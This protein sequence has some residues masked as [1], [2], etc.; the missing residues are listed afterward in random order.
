MGAVFALL[1]GF[2]YWIPKILGK[3]YSEVLGKI[4]FWTLFL[5]VFIMTFKEITLSYI[6]S[7]YLI[8]INGIDFVLCSN[9][10]FITPF[11]LY[12]GKKEDL[13]S[14]PENMI[15]YNVETNIYNI[16][17]EIKGKAG[18]H[19]LVSDITGDTYIGSSTNLR[20]RIGVYYYQVRSDSNSKMYIIRA[21]K[22]YGLHNFCFIILDYCEP[23]REVCLRL[24]QLAF[25]LYFPT[26]NILK[27]AGSSKGF[28]H[29]PETIA[30]LKERFSGINHPKYGSSLNPNTKEAISNALKNYYI[31][32]DHPSINKKGELSPQYG[33]GGK[34]IYVYE[35]S[36][37]TLVKSF[38]SINAAIKFIK[39]KYSLLM[40][41]L[42]KGLLLKDKWVVSF[43]PL[44][45]NDPI[46]S[47]FI[48]PE[49]IVSKAKAKGN[50]LRL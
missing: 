9:L 30:Y 4:H 37:K 42:T 32:R 28:S 7:L 18:T 27:I 26:Y 29:S 19:M 41:A 36:T 25:N 11:L 38:P 8:P 43:T 22:K 50:K 35:I 49:S 17:S 5:G 45:N 6:F 31:D 13:K 20:K 2:Y 39:V 16:Y 1:A 46:F 24:E 47:N 33:I 12:Q 15:W 3:N 10:F 21:L 14:R 40:E 48:V 44:S 23:N 34:P